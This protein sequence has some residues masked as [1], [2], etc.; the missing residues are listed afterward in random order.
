MA[1]EEPNDIIKNVLCKNCT[2]P[3]Y[4]KTESKKNK[5]LQ[6]VTCE[7]CGDSYHKM[8]TDIGTKAWDIVTGDNESI[9]FK[10]P[11][12]IVNKGKKFHEMKEIKNEISDVKN[13]MKNEMKALL[14]E[15]NN[16]ML[17]QFKDLMFPEVEKM[18]DSKLKKHADAVDKKIEEKLPKVE[19]MIDQKLKIHANEIDKK[20]EEKIRHLEEKTDKAVDDKMNK[21]ISAEV[22]NKEEQIVIE[23]K[24]QKQVSQSFDELKEREERKTNLIVY[25]V[26]ESAADDVEE[27]AREDLQNVKLVLKHTNPDLSNNIIEQLTV[28]KISRLGNKEKEVKKDEATPDKKEEPNPENNAQNPN[29][30]DESKINKKKES[31]PRPIKLSLPDE[32]TKFKILG[33]SK[34]LRNYQAQANI[35]IKPDLTRQQQLE[36]KELRQQ[37]KK[38]KEDGEDVMIYKNKIILREEHAKL[39]QEFSLKTTNQ[40]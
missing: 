9:L 10:C 38:R 27:Q 24:I 8:C 7:E 31:K 30:D 35:G 36:D 20:I 5:E 4:E 37:L 39:K 16:L 21:K 23:D 28:D 13:E 19:Q 40:Q 26:S 15:N 22:L 6:Y 18:I 33:N 1:S 25:N 3:C 17:K 29:N 11:P 14:L 2:K 32:K 34:T 12:C